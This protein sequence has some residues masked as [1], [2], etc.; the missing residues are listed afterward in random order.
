MTQEIAITHHIDAALVE[1]LET[2][3]GQLA[4]SS[5][6]TYRKDTKHFAVWLADACL[7]LVAIG[8]DD[9]VRYRKHLQENYAKA[10]AARM[11]TV[12]KRLLSEA[13]KR[14]VRAD[15]PA[16]DIRGFKSGRDET[17]HTALSK[18]QARELLDSMNRATRMGQRDYAL[19]LLLLRTG[20]RRSEAAGLTIGD[21]RQEVGH[22][23]VV[24]RH[25]KGDV[26]RSAKVPVDVLRVV[27]E[28]LDAIGHSNVGADT[29]L[30]VQF[31]KGD[32][33]TYQALSDSSIERIVIAAGRAIGVDLTPHGLRASFV[34]LALEGGAK[35]Q[36]VQYAAGH[37]DPRTTERYQKRKLNLDDNA[38]DFIRL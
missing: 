29:P 30:F 35:L 1:T 8:R 4:P 36:Q 12:A 28:Y 3:A 19:V 6:D 32:K 13:V 2:L 27:R 34:T 20:I 38:V 17:P 24:I 5:A 33:A 7:D 21:L 10:T 18:A 23:I 37:A 16:A 25:G 11:L 9:I 14:G 22:T 26:R 31:V 15:N